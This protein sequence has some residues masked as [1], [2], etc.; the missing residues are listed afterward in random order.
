M[1]VID[2]FAGLEGWSKPFRERGHNVFSVDFNPTFKVDLTKNILDVKLSDFPWKPDVV[3]ASPPCDSF[4]LLSNKNWD[5]STPISIKSKLGLK[6]LQR[7]VTLIHELDPKY[8]IIEN[9]RGKMRYML[10]VQSLER[11]TVTY[12]QYGM[13]YMKPTDLWGGFNPSLVL[14]PACFKG[15]KCHE[16]VSKGMQT[17]V[18]A[19]TSAYERSLIPYQLALEVCLFLEKDLCETSN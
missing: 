2:L 19:L 14:R 9:P 11:R 13:P 16:Y 3:L 18:C 4:S 7:T 1:N 12:C 15:A 17:G 6:V 8:F 10:E 5:G